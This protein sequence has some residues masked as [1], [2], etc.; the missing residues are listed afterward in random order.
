MAGVLLTGLG[1]WVG[2]P[3]GA[4]TAAPVARVAQ[5]ATTQGANPGLTL[6]HNAEG[7]L[8]LA[9]PASL[10]VKF[11]PTGA[12]IGFV[13]FFTGLNETGDG[14]AIY[15][16][17]NVPATKCDDVPVTFFSNVSDDTNEAITFGVGTCASKGPIEGT[18]G[19]GVDENVYGS[20]VWIIG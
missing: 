4:A 19:P 14:V 17:D 11:C 16:G 5:V 7:E 13:C 10:I 6:G 20:D 15:R 8:F 2:A 18:D 1:L 3:V 9:G 12:E